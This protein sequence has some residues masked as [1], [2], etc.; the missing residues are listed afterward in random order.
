M[1]VLDQGVSTSIAK[2]STSTCSPA[3]AGWPLLGS[4]LV[5]TSCGKRRRRST[6]VFGNVEP[7]GHTA[8][9]RARG[10]RKCLCVVDTGLDFHAGR[11]VHLHLVRRPP[12]GVVKMKESQQ[13]VLR[14]RQCER[15]GIR[16]HQRCGELAGREMP[17]QCRCRMKG[18]KR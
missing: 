18:T 2:V 11:L 12:A 16:R 9:A 14:V 1:A 6:H 8:N 7:V 5:M 10:I 15:A 17:G 13:P 3:Q 4:V